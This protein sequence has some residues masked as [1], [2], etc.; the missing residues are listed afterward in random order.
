[1]RAWRAF[2]VAC[3][4]V[5]PLGRPAEASCPIP[6]CGI[7]CG[8][9]CGGLYDCGPCSV[10]CGNGVCQPGLGET[11][12][13]CAFDCPP[14]GCTSQGCGTACG[15]V[16]DNCGQ[17]QQCGA[18]PS[19]CGNG[20]CESGERMS[21][22]QDCPS[23]CHPLRHC[24]TRCGVIDDGCGSYLDCGP[25][26]G[27]CGNN[28]CEGWRGETHQSCP[29]DCAPPSCQSQGCGQRCGQ[30]IDNCGQALN[31]GP[32]SALCAQPNGVCEPGL[33]ENPLTCPNECDDLCGN[34]QCDYMIERVRCPADCAA[35]D[36]ALLT[37]GGPYAG[38]AGEALTFHAAAVTPG[39]SVTS[40]D[41]TFGDG[42]SASGRAVTHAYSQ[43]GT[44]DVR[45]RATLGTG[46]VLT[47]DTTAAIGVTTPSGACNPCVSGGF[48]YDSIVDALTLHVR[49]SYAP[50]APGFKAFLA[51]SIEDPAGNPVHQ[52]PFTAVGE[53]V[54]GSQHV[55]A[56]GQPQAGL[57]KAY[58]VVL[59]VDAI[60]GTPP[61]PYNWFVSIVVPSRTCNGCVQVTPASAMIL[62]GDTAAFGAGWPGHSTVGSWQWRAEKPAGAGPE[63][64]VTFAGNGA[65]NVT[66]RATWFPR[67]PGLHCPS[68]PELR[69]EM[70][71]KYTVRVDAHTSTSIGN[72]L[73]DLT[74]TMP[75]GMPANVGGTGQPAAATHPP[76]VVGPLP[77]Y[78][79]ECTE[80]V[81]PNS[82]RVVANRWSRSLPYTTIEIAT[83]SSFRAKIEAH[84]A[85]HRQ[86][87]L[88]GL[89][90]AL[91]QPQ[92]LYAV[93][94]DFTAGSVSQ[95]NALVIAAQNAFNDAQEA[96]YRRLGDVMEC[97]AYAISDLHTP[98]YLLQRC[99]VRT[100]LQCTP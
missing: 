88:D 74:V 48:S 31:C 57:W 58:V 13:N 77:R 51:L 41:W 64:G 90:G 61:Q 69:A 29:S 47:A 8:L 98:R 17:Q 5:S 59:V 28:V 66:A 60:G 33:G 97:A 54:V 32:C 14:P 96:E 62:D 30:W 92:A 79:P 67:T 15:L 53:Q 42:S 89:A 39:T 72:G 73:A 87:F 81:V 34:G 68:A 65:P 20:Q 78:N 93:V 84:E 52:L 26:T 43:P 24:G 76:Q 38:S 80:Q 95:L 50:P 22:P 1:M 75:W 99:V 71:P 19:Q 86:Q 18:C 10:L 49:V 85:A 35:P 82:C 44:Y 3:A 40:Y 23:G 7:Q 70:K 55:P 4:L 21:C 11:H 56:L 2:L 37:A 94:S 63:G 16:T 36:Q 100:D 45:A 9:I 83:S 25:C 91:W 27:V 46:Q 12:V 6:D